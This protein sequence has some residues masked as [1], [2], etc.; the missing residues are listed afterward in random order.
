VSY[1][2]RRQGMDPLLI[3]GIAISVLLHGALGVWILVERTGGAPKAV[4]VPREFVV[5]RM[6]R[7]GHKR[8][9]GWL[10]K[11]PPRAQAPKKHV[12]LTTNENA[13]A[14]KKKDDEKIPG[15]EEGKAMVRAN[16][17]AKVFAEAQQELDVEGD[18][19]GS[20]TGTATEATPGDEYATAC[21]EEVRKYWTV[22]PDIQL[23]DSTLGRLTAEVRIVIDPSGKVYDATV[24]T[25][26][27]NRYFDA[28]L[29]DALG[30]LKKLPR[31]PKSLVRDYP[32]VGIVLV[33]EGKDLK[34]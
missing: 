17:L 5:A 16:S 10:P 24:K 12:G 9:P 2:A 13:A 32:K 8:P 14:A 28:S 22:P 20:P 11:I 15:A 34:R 29:K 6:V 3:L 26:S 25:Q 21:A 33:F 31:P 19:R 23:P 7:L 27:R 1:L 4:E 18:P 30:R